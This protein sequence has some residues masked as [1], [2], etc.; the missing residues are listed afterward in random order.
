MDLKFEKVYHFTDSEIVKAM[1]NKASYGFNTFVANRIGEIQQATSPHEW[2]WINEKINVADILTRGCTPNELDENSIWQNGPQFL[3]WSED[4]WPKGNNEFIGVLPD[5]KRTTS[6]E[7]GENDE[8]KGCH[9]SHSGKFVAMVEDKMVTRKVDSLA[10]RI[11]INRFSSYTRLLR[12]TARVCAMYKKR[13]SFKNVA[14]ELSYQQLKEAEMFWVQEAQR[15]ITDLELSH[16]YLRLSPCKREDGIIVVGRRAEKWMSISYNAEKPILLPYNHAISKLYVTQV[17]NEQHLCGFSG[18]NAT[19]CKVR[20]KFWVVRIEQMPKSIKY[21]CVTCK[22]MNKLVESQIMGRIPIDRLKPA[23]AWHSIS[24]DFF[25][26]FETRGEVNKRSRGK[27]YGV[28]FTCNL[29]RAV[30]IDVSHD[31]S[32]DA[33]LTVLRRF[34]PI[35]GSP[36]IIRSDRGSQLVG[37]NKEL[38]RMIEGLD[39][40]QLQQFGAQSSFEWQFSPGDAPWQ[41]GCAESMVKAVKK[42]I[43]AVIGQQVLTNA[44]LITVMFEIANLLNERPIGKRSNDIDDGTYLCPNDLLLGRATTRVP[45]GPFDSNVTPR[46]RFR[47]LQNLVNGFWTKMMKFYFPTLLVQQKWH[48]SRRNAQRG[49]I[50]ILQDTNAVRGNWRLGKICEVHTSSDG[51]VRRVTVEYKNTDDTSDYNGRPW[52]NVELAIQRL[53]VVLPAEFELEG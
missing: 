36:S 49:D 4:K 26:P 34:I 18:I 39:R 16:K 23:P 38:K 41:N 7:H 51:T 24:V 37:A 22:K 12:V 28:V 10:E 30:H 50:V 53:I 35:R 44:E 27:A 6:A 5:Q 1:V 29:I 19:V 45:S 46:K 52:V 33:F 2:I 17:H 11:N 32:T 40:P 47:F 14:T 15:T 8:V 31:Y 43:T 21:R 3:Q 42:A 20:L 9:S 25:G 13:P 48:T